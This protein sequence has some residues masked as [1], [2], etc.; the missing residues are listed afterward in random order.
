MNFKIFQSIFVVFKAT[1]KMIK[2]ALEFIM[3]F[4]SYI[5]A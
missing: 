3:Y 4:N 5:A 2:F 1:S